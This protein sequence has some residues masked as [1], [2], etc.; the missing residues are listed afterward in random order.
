MTRT[1]EFQPLDTNNAAHIQSIVELWNRTC[2]TDLAISPRFAA[3]NL[4]APSGGD[5]NT[6]FAVENGKA[7]GFV[8][9][10]FLND[11][12]ITGEATGWIDAIAVEPEAQR[13]GIGS[14]LLQWAAAWHA[15]KHATMIR[16]GASLRPFVPGVPEQLQSVG[17]FQRHGFGLTPEHNAQEWDLAANLAHYKTP[18]TVR[19]IDAIVRP[20]QPADREAMLEFFG[21]EFPGR[22]RYEFEQYTAE[23]GRISDYMVLWTERGVDGCAVLTFEDSVHPIER[24]Y[25][26]RLPRPWGQLGSIGVS[27]DRRGRGYGSA[28]IDAALRRLHNNSVNGCVIDWT[29]LVDFYAKFGFHRYRAYHLL[30]KKL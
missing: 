23:G 1:L 15:T 8:S 17:F 29:D 7:V 19:E 4:R 27:E 22:W 26:Y 30:S 12:L 9:A 21:R 18:R 5:Q 14:A 6:C 10:S 24:F 20:A 25:P 2:G 13:Q 11:P 16:I 3:Y 28:L